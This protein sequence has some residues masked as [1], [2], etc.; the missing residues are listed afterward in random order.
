MRIRDEDIPKW[1][2][3]IKCMYIKVELFRWAKERSLIMYIPSMAILNFARPHL[4]FLYVS[5]ER[6][7]VLSVFWISWFVEKNRE[8]SWETID[9]S[10][11]DF[12]SL[13]AVAP[14]YMCH[15]NEGESR[16]LDANEYKTEVPNT[17]ESLMKSNISPVQIPFPL[18]RSWN[19]A[20]RDEARDK[21][22]N[23]DLSY[24]SFS[25]RHMKLFP[26]CLGNIILLFLTYFHDLSA[27][28]L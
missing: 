23:T 17:E 1:E 2:Y 4:V 16:A 19:D 7:H 21:F 28:I 15:T 24:F 8:S 18:P 6:W 25:N 9:P 22:D 20:D 14:W 12:I 27:I 13:N 26:L 10:I 3:I 5:R 11:R